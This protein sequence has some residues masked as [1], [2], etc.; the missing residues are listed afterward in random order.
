MTTPVDERAYLLPEAAAALEI[1]RTLAA[2]VDSALTQL[3]V[4]AKFRDQRDTYFAARVFVGEIRT[5]AAGV[6]RRCDETAASL[7]RLNPRS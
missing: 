7:D 4:H 6:L 5:F 2:S 3:V 1:T